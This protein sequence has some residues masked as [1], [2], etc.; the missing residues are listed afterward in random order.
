MALPADQFV[1]RA[2]NHMSRALWLDAMNMK[3]RSDVP[4]LTSIRN[5][6]GPYDELLFCVYLLGVESRRLSV[7]SLFSSPKSTTTV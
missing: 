3:V 6:D 4:P 1:T 7:Y 2:L 5:F